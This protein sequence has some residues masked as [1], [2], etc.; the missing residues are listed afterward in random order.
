MHGSF[1][2]LQAK[3]HAFEYQFQSLSS[4]NGLS[5]NTVNDIAEDSSGFIWIG[6][7]NG[8]NRFDGVRVINYLK[9][10]P[11]YS[12]AENAILDLHIDQQGE[13]WV[14]TRNFI[15]IK[16]GDQFEVFLS[17]EDEK[18]TNFDISPRHLKTSSKGLLFLIGNQGIYEIHKDKKKLRMS[19]Y[20]DVANSATWFVMDSVVQDNQVIL[21]TT[22]GLWV[23]ND[24]KEFVQSNSWP[25][26]L[27]K[28][29]IQTALANNNG[30]IVNGVDS[31]Y[32]LDNQL[33]VFSIDTFKN[34]Q[35]SSYPFLLSS[36]SQLHSGLEPH[37]LWFASSTELFQWQLD[38][39]AEN[40]LLNSQPSRVKQF[41]SFIQ[42]IFVDSKN[43]VW[44]GTSMQGALYLSND[45]MR[46]K[47]LQKKALVTNEPFVVTAI[48]GSTKDEFWVGTSSGELYRYDQQGLDRLPVITDNMMNYPKIVSQIN[49]IVKVNE[50]LWLGTLV[51][52][53]IYDLKTHEVIN[54]HAQKNSNITF[55]DVLNLK[56]IGDEL[57]VVSSNTGIF[58]IDLK[59][60]QFKLLRDFSNWNPRWSTQKVISILDDKEVL[61]LGT[62]EGELIR[63]DRKTETF[64]QIAAFT[65]MNQPIYAM[66]K[67]SH[68][69]I[70]FITNETLFEYNLANQVITPHLNAYDVG[71][72]AFYSL[73]LDELNRVW[74][75]GSRAL[76][77]YEPTSKARQAFSAYDGA[78][79]SEYNSSGLIRQERL[80]LGS[81][82]GITQINTASVVLPEKQPVVNIEYRILKDKK[83]NSVNKKT[84][85][86]RVIVMQG[87]AQLRVDISPVYFS[88]LQQIKLRYRINDNPWIAIDNWRVA[89]TGNQFSAGN[90]KLQIQ[91]AWQYSDNWKE[92]T[93]ISVS[94]LGLW[95]IP[96]YIYWIIASA[97]ML[98]FLVF[99]KFALK[100]RYH[101]EL[102][103]NQRVEKRTE[104]L[105][106]QLAE[107][108]QLHQLTKILF[109]K[110]DR[111]KQVV[112]EKGIENSK[113]AELE[114]R[115]WQLT[116]NINSHLIELLPRKQEHSV[117][118]FLMNCINK[119]R[120]RLNDS[121]RIQI[122]D[123]QR[124]KTHFSPFLVGLCLDAAILYIE[125]LNQTTTISINVTK[126]S[127]RR[128][129]IT[130]LSRLNN[131]SVNRFNG[132]Y[133][134]EFDAIF[135]F[136]SNVIH[137]LNFQSELTINES[138][139]SWKLHFPV[140]QVW[141]GNKT[142]TKQQPSLL[143]IQFRDSDKSDT[144]NN[145]QTGLP[146]VLAD[147]THGQ[148][149][150]LQG[151]LSKSQVIQKTYFYQRLAEQF[152]IILRE[153]IDSAKPVDKEESQ[154]IIIRLDEI[155]QPALLQLF[156]IYK[157]NYK[158]VIVVC[159]YSIFELLRYSERRPANLLIFPKGSSPE[160]IGHVLQFA[161]NIQRQ[162]PEAAKPKEVQTFSVEELSDIE[163]ADDFV[164]RLNT[165]LEKYC[166]D[167]TLD[168]EKVA[169]ELK[170][171]S[172]HLARKMKHHLNT[173]TAEYIK[174]F[175][176]K[177]A[178]SLLQ[179]GLPVKQVSK[180]TGFSSRSYFTTCF[181]K[182]FGVVPSDYKNI[183]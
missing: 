81:T 73:E 3:N 83:K 177:K 110:L 159:P 181:K 104:A 45:F 166:A 74:L 7:E 36:T 94:V 62:S 4:Q 88:Q 140:A 100:W 57:W 27:K 65:E 106:S 49:G 55:T 163:R 173:S 136:L 32:W 138:L 160:L 167:Q 165:F 72:A 41:N 149:S 133:N 127:A 113:D 155:E 56:R 5:Q 97:L 19:A 143:N 44:L 28:G 92:E 11:Q 17:F 77:L 68:D 93:S 47:V 141:R 148:E 164:E 69:I 85:H 171:S 168:V 131:Q 91:S 15:L 129:N 39:K 18:N 122:H 13:F 150:N 98:L 48:T 121:V 76:V 50:Q 29:H 53:L 117:N 38:A 118:R 154:A 82:S 169:F 20:P 51:G 102:F 157:E 58:R 42:K 40:H 170:L 70:W 26:K 105:T 144:D 2:L 109:E 6:T 112:I 84:T 161:L 80:F 162:Q 25:E 179:K 123:S 8:L 174:A 22:Q 34:A 64:S 116:T 125:S 60:N 10:A 147:L 31:L 1:A 14:L 130:I 132:E 24:K 153:S 114:T 172:R 89:L 182:E 46:F 96:V 23:Y 183:S 9:N 120:N 71:Q 78:L 128:G 86:S 151:R 30:V 54:W 180:M 90:H 126:S 21:S 134:F 52:L 152:T 59:T 12:I 178:L 79:T 175:R 107:I 101:S 75:G 137:E 35:F 16:R 61:Y 139:F 43:N 103:F 146:L 99:F 124:L 115:L 37:H 108:E 87:G 145:I 135:T 156:D 142:E 33:N 63:F 66:A 67:K 158:C 176:L 119:N 111:I 95:G